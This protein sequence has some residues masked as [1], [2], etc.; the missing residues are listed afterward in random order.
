MTT[1]VKARFCQFW[2]CTLTGPTWIRYNHSR[3]FLVDLTVDFGI[4]AVGGVEENL[5]LCITL[6]LEQSGL[7]AVTLPARQKSCRFVRHIFLII[8][9]GQAVGRFL[10]VALVLV[11]VNTMLAST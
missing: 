1:F 11:G 2:S 5:A 7:A 8:A 4:A 9:V 6:L 3:N 10:R